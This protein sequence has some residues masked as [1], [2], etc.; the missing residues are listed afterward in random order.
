[1]LLRTV[2]GSAATGAELARDLRVH[3]ERIAAN[4]QA[5]AVDLL[6][7]R[8]GF[9]DGP[10]APADYLGDSGLLTDRLIAAAAAELA[11]TAEL[12]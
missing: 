2:G 11:S 1:M 10:A 4:L 5:A 3:E 8:A 6:A 12:A 9:A 7:E